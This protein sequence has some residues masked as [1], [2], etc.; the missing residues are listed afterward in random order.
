MR[1]NPPLFATNSIAAVAHRP[2]ARFTCSPGIEILSRAL[3]K[4]MLFKKLDRAATVGATLSELEAEVDGEELS[5]VEREEAWLY[6][7]ALHRHQARRVRSRQSERRGYDDAGY[8][9]AG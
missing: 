2:P 7:W 3:K 8:T 9:G 4:T 1:A 6:V 5:D